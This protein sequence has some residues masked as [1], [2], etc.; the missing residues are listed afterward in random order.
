MT[1]IAQLHVALENSFFKVVK[2]N[3]NL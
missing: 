2:N 1:T 3:K